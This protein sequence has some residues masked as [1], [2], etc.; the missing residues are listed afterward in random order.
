[1]DDDT[2]LVVEE[3]GSRNLAGVTKDIVVSSEENTSIT[4]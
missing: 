2:V 1:M 4:N 3:F